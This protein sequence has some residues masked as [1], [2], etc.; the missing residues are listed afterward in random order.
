MRF[1]V[2]GTG[3]V[4]GYFGGL[5]A[6]AGTEVCFIARGD[7]LKA[8]KKNGLR[9]ESIEPGDFTVKDA[10]FTDDPSEAGVCDVVL[11]CV[12]T[13]ANVVA[14]PAIRPMVGRQTVIITL[15]NGVDNPAQLAAE[16]GKEQVMGGVAYL[17]TSLAEPG[18][19][20]QTGGPRRLVFGEMEGGVSLRGEQIFNAFKSS[21]VNAELSADIRVELW[22][23]FVFICAV[24]GMTAL[25]RSS[26][27]EI[28]AY[29]GTARMMREVM[30]E[31]YK[32]AQAMEISIP[33]ATDEKNFQ[34]LSQQNP[35]SKGSLCYDLEAGRRLEI[36]AL[37]GTVSKLGK[38]KGVSTPIN[39]YIYHTLKLADLKIGGAIT[40]KA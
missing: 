7:H 34:F 22:K 8:L 27:G 40:L 25:T 26:I 14:I 33:E 28:M 6:R 35:A 5:L 1:G 2:M 38:E 39:D 32:L 16:Y 3:A 37:C 19:V 15:Q 20:K 17:F 9:V 23:K 29:E 21:S 11:F 12:K 10:L 18:V 31:V 4:G 24:S 30:R 13:V 36:D